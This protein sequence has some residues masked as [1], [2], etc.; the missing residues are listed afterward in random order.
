L[1][2]QQNMKYYKDLKDMK[3]RSD[4]IDFNCNVIWKLV[5]FNN[6]KLQNMFR[7]SSCDL[8]ANLGT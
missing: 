5:L 4:I 2:G 7:L 6:E 3:F 8:N 1:H